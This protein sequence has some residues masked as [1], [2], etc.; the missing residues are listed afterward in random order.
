MIFRSIFLPKLFK[1]NTFTIHTCNI[2][3]TANVTDS[4]V[5]N[6]I[7]SEMCVKREAFSQ[8]DDVRNYVVARYCNKQNNNEMQWDKF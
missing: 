7:N 3:K 8:S 1:N 5:V 2:D 6:S 4:N